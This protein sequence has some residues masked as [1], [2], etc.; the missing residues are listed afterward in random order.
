MLAAGSRP[1]AA[2]LMQSSNFRLDP[3]V[4]ASFGGA[5]SST[6][7]SLSATG[8]EPI[9][10]AGASQS[11]M[12]GGGYN[13]QLPQSIQLSVL[14]SGTVADWSLDTGSG[15]AAY[16]NSLTGND[17]VLQGAPTWATGIVNQGVLLNGSSQY[18]ST[19]ISGAAPQIFTIEIWFKSTTGNGGRLMGFGST[20][21]GASGT[22]DRHLYLDNAGHIIWGVSSSG[23]QTVATAATYNDGSWHHVAASLGAGGLLLNVDGV[24]QGT[25]LGITTAAN[26]TGYWRAGYD[27]LSGWPSAPTSSYLAATI[28]EARVYNRQL[29]DQ[30]INNDYLAGFASLQNAFTLPDIVPGT[31]QTYLAD[32]IVRTEA[33]GYD[34]YM[35]KTAP[36]THTDTTT[37]IPDISSSISS[38]AAWSEGT[39][40]G[41]GFTLT[42]GTQL[43]GAWGTNPNY[44]YAAIPST[45][46][47]Y[48]TRTGENGGVAEVTTIQ[49]RADTLSTQKQGLYKTTIIYSATAKP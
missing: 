10:G 25:N 7:Y 38:P 3:N 42:A 18:L 27:N 39:T 26:Y 17:G 43:S 46:E 15:T 9:V 14:P 29:T 33:P 35:N 24:R 36:L 1:A 49:Y 37:T 40:K 41:V 5:G 44:M 12:L 20:A 22:L 6:S 19:S 34:L 28:D 30:E 2:D 4:A 13:A 11:F 48:H 23:Q 21:T 16:D 8:G 31:S 32:A 45:S 47:L